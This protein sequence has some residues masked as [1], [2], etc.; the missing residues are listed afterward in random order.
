MAKHQTRRSIS[1]NGSLYDRAKDLAD[2]QGISLSAMCEHGL[3][4]AM[5]APESTVDGVREAAA[6]RVSA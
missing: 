1:I 3:R 6:R 5:A 4:L 2:R